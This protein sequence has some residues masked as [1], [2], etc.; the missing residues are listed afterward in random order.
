[1]DDRLMD[2]WFTELLD[3][4]MNE[5]MGN[6][7]DRCITQSMHLRGTISFQVCIEL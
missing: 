6:E 3:I 2:G 5:F 4:Q 7:R 1:M